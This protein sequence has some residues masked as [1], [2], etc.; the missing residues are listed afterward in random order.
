MTGTERDHFEGEIMD[1]RDND[2]IK[3]KER[4]LNLRA[5]FLQKIIVDD[6]GDNV[7][8]STDIVELGKK[9]AKVLNMLWLEARKLSGLDED[10]LE[11]L[12]KN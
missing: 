10:D 4:Y 5:K 3:A 6:N 9:N 2:K 8:T 7:F 1:I 11:E 12:E